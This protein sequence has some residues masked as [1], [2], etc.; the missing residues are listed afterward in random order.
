MVNAQL[1]K[2]YEE[3]LM[4]LQHQITSFKANRKLQLTL[5]IILKL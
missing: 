5:S 4:Q 2:L 1:K 3:I